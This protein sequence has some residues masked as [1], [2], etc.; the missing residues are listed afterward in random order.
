[1]HQDEYSSTSIMIYM[2]CLERLHKCY[3]CF[4]VSEFLS[5]SLHV[6]R[7]VRFPSVSSAQQVNSSG[8]VTVTNFF[9]RVSIHLRFI[10]SPFCNILKHRERCDQRL[11]PNCCQ[12][13]F[14]VLSGRM[15]DALLLLCC[16]RHGA[17]YGQI[18]RAQS[19]Q[20]RG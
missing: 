17:T 9:W 2:R 11:C 13:V 3:L 19:V 18:M 5:L 14:V 7:S 16:L 12:I 10:C 15:E 1:M 20:N 6:L 8:N 4:H